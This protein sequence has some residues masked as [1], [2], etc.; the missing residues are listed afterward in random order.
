VTITVTERDDGG[1]IQARVGDLIELRLP[2]NASTGYRWTL[3]HLDA[4]L[5]ELGD[6]GADY[7]DKRIGSGGEVNFRITVVAAGN[8][9]LALKCWRS[10]EGDGGV[11]KRFAVEVVSSSPR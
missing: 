3:D 11:L 8:A 4:R 9:T 6:T 5:F 7:P 10:W 1:R 2:E